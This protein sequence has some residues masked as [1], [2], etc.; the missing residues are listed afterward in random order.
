MVHRRLGIFGL[1]FVL[2]AA[3]LL[4]WYSIDSQSLWLDELWGIEIACGHGAEHQVLPTDRLLVEPP[5]LT[6]LQSAR[7]TWA[8]WSH[9][10]RIAGPPGSYL[11]LRGWMELFGQS[12]SSLRGL[13]VLFSLAVIPVF[14]WLVQRDLGTVP[15]LCAITFFAVA[16]TQIHYAQDARPYSLLVFEAVCT[17]AVAQ[18]IARGNKSRWW[19]AL[20]VVAMLSKLLT[21][22]FA[23]TLLG[24]IGGWAMFAQPPAVRRR[25]L[26]CV[27]ITAIVFAVIWGPM[28]WRQLAV[29]SPHDRAAAFLHETGPGHVANTLWRLLTMPMSLISDRRPIPYWYSVGGLIYL[30]GIGWAWVRRRGSWGLLVVLPALLLAMLDLSRG[31]RHLEYVRYSIL[32]S[33]AVY[34][35]LAAVVKEYP[36]VGG[37]VCTAVLVQ[38]LLALPGV[39]SPQNADFRAFGESINATCARGDVIVFAGPAE[40]YAPQILY[41]AASHYAWPL[42]GPVMLIESPASPAAMEQLRSYDHVYL[43]AD[44][45]VTSARTWLPG[46]HIAAGK[47]WPVVGSLLEMRRN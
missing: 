28:M 13:S 7:P 16:G 10:D 38:C 6:D 17:L 34:V 36:R 39:Y 27:A 18:Q 37:V 21:H 31:T 40:I 1:L 2:T 32:A 42:P 3:G 11:L 14:F 29:F 43:A 45:K 26:V 5:G 35:A 24:V 25:L 8:V 20:L 19:S 22:Y 23:I 44:P 30:W 47:S 33:L 12:E 9:M 46:F 15:A 4:R 41:L